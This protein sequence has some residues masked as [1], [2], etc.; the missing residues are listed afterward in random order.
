MDDALQQELLAA[1][2]PDEKA[3]VVAEA[4]FNTL[5]EEMAL[6]ARRCSLLHWFDGAIVEALS[7][8]SQPAAG[9]ARAFYKQ[10]ESF[11]MIETMPWGLAF[12]RLTREG[13]LQRYSST[14][15]ELLRTAAH[16]AASAY[17]AREQRR[18]HSE[19]FFCSLVAGDR[20]AAKD[21]LDELLARAISRGD[22]EYVG[23]LMRMQD[24]AESLP[25]VQPLSLPEEYR[26]IRLY[27][28]SVLV[29]PFSVEKPHAE[30]AF[31]IKALLRDIQPAKQRRAMEESA[32]LFDVCIVCA[33]PEEARAFLEVVQE[34]YESALEERISPRYRYSYRST[35]LKNDKGELLN[36]HISWL[37]RYGPQEMTL[38]LSHVLEE[39]QPRIA[40]MTGICAGDAQHVRLG[41][42]VVAE[43]TFTYDTG[44]F[45]LDEQG[46]SVHEHD[47][48][49][50]Q[51]DANILQFLGLFDKW[52]PLI[53]TL[54][55]PPSPPEQRKEHD[56]QMPKERREITCHLKAM[57]SGS[58]VRADHPFKDVRVP[59]R[60]AVAIDMEGA[61]FG[62]VMSHH[63]LIRWL[64]VKSVC[65]YADQNKNDVYHDYAARASALYALSFI[66][67]YV[68]HE[69]L[70]RSH[71]VIPLQNP[72]RHS[73]ILPLEAAHPLQRS[74]MP[75]PPPPP[76]QPRHLHSPSFVIVLIVL[77]LILLGGG[78]LGIYGAATGHL[79]FGQPT[80]IPSTAIATPSSLSSPTPT[81][82][83]GTVLFRA[84]WSSGLNS[85]GPPDGDIGRSVW[86]TSHG[87][88]VC[89]GSQGGGLGGPLL[90]LER[91]QLPTPNYAIEA[92]IQITAIDPNISGIYFGLLT[93]ESSTGVGYMAGVG[94]D[95]SLE[96]TIFE[97][98]AAIELPRTETS[99][100]DAVGVWHT[101]RVEAKNNTIK[102]FIDGTF[103]FQES[104]QQNPF[105][106]A[107]QNGL[108]GLACSFLHLVV[109]SF[110]VTAL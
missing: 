78:S 58:A 64:V 92:R 79:P 67:A 6:L 37:P 89:D 38:H 25:F 83:P 5:P 66:R 20:A 24:E 65:D 99:Y 97:N 18:S 23:G 102:L 46:R 36:L 49:T 35:T 54:E 43:R 15:P 96:N 12:N 105:L 98:D 21:L 53:T 100:T 86:S 106:Q 13:L 14:Q 87:M 56:I 75:P 84:N 101:Y 85:W 51:L 39:C 52:K 33:L 107:G 28:Y 40:I 72:V 81:L 71:T 82:S 95:T 103:M 42:L 90:L 104:V 88:L 91:Q 69:R 19:A 55:R 16:L 27:A 45:T 22:W 63:P 29:R 68:T 31:S 44:K 48:M 109:S 94:G 61:A 50:Y 17:R 30:G 62:S 108:T 41:D 26:A 7:E 8:K 34:P 59:V 11:P 10:F 2:Y 110:Q 1:K 9:E 57:A 77:V 32:Q 93:R 47:T 74:A 76:S 80:S 4:L 3:A 60:G 70:P 73:P